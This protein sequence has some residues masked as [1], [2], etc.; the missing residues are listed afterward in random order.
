MHSHCR[1][2]S[3]KAYNESYVLAGKL[4]EIREKKEAN[5]VVW[6]KKKNY[7]ALVQC[8]NKSAC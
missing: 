7:G 2:L 3:K 4:E 1:I 8:G 6:V 5:P